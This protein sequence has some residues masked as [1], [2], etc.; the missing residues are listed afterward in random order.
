[1]DTTTGIVI[2]IFGVAVTCIFGW[3]ALRRRY[4][5]RIT[6]F[7]ESSIGLFDSIVR[8]IGD[9]KVLYKDEPVSENMVLLKGYI[10]NTGSKDITRDMIE[11]PLTL[12]LPDG[13]RWLDAKVVPSKSVV[14]GKLQIKQTTSAT[15]ELGLFRVNEYVRF[16][17][18]AQVPP[19]ESQSQIGYEG[20]AVARLRE[21]LKVEHRIADSRRVIHREIPSTSPPFGFIIFFFVCALGFLTLS[22]LILLGTLQPW[23]DL[24]FLID[25]GSGQAIEAKIDIQRDGTIVVKGVNYPFENRQPLAEFFAGCNFKPKAAKSPLSTVFFLP[26][27]FL[28]AL[29]IS[30]RYVGV[31]GLPNQAKIQKD[32]RFGVKGM[33]LIQAYQYRVEKWES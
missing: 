6:Y 1:M 26:F 2:G 31:Q 24:H 15:F 16:E 14:E 25:S 11:K 18:L 33:L 10:M 23:R 28:W 30:T 32:S 19:S 29:V 27:F 12:K 13:F 21:T 20:N 5:G 7:E 9:L 3:L 22:F 8:N 4:P 17:A